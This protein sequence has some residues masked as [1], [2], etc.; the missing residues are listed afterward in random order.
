MRQIEIALPKTLT[1]C[2]GLGLCGDSLLTASGDAIQ[3][4][5]K[6]RLSSFQPPKAE[7]AGDI[8]GPGGARH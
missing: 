5:P 2:L 3:A 6:H 8:G 1:L 7:A 4:L